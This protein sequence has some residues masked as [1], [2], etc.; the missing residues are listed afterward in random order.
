MQYVHLVDAVS[1]FCS[2]MLDSM[3][4]CVLLHAWSSG[5]NDLSCY[6]PVHMGLAMPL[7]HILL[8]THTHTHTYLHTHTYKHTGTHRNTLGRTLFR[9]RYRLYVQT[10][11]YVYVC[12]CVRMCVCV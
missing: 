8:D 4:A 9:F 3:P 12:V 7:V 1:G 2:H 6:V 5:L 11:L 10:C